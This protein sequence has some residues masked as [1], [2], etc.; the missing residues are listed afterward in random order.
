MTNKTGSSK[1]FELPIFCLGTGGLAGNPQD[2]SL[3]TDQATQVKILEYALAQFHAHGMRPWIDTALHYGAGNALKSIGLALGEHPNKDIVLSIKVGRVLEK[4]TPAEPYE[5]GPFKGEGE[6]NRRF[7]YSIEGTLG[8]FNQSFEFLNEERLKHG[9]RA[10]K[11]QDINTIV[12]V[13]DPERRAHGDKADGIIKQ[14]KDEAFPA[15]ATLKRE[16]KIKAIGV[17]TN[18]IACALQLVEHPDLDLVMVAGRFTLLS[19]HAAKAPQEI[20]DDTQGLLTLLDKV[21]ELGKRII[22]A[23]PG[24]SGLL[25]EGG[26]WY[27][28]KPAS[29]E[30]MAFRNQI[31]SVTEK[32][33]VPLAAAALQFPLM[34]GASAVV[35]GAASSEELSKTLADFKRPIPPALWKELQKS[36]LINPHAYC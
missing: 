36:E 14:V 22:C 9:W 1:Q 26:S 33:N 10:I 23:A 32:H 18:E 27:N 17:G 13:H 4:P 28:Y 12:F 29:T 31:K 11:P 34:A 6:Y 35:C 7:D 2:A 8:A 21:H 3:P 19:N 5:Q 15:L 24:N 30:V 16:G 25:Y 20:L